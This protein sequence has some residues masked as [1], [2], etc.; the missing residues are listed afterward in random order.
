MYSSLT[1]G[2]GWTD[3]PVGRCRCGCGGQT[4][5]AK[6]GDPRTGRVKG[7]PLRYLP[8]HHTRRRTPYLRFWTGHT[9]DC[10]IWLGG[11]NRKG[12]GVTA[13]RRGGCALAHRVYYEEAKGPIPEG[14]Q[15]DHLCCLP[16]CVN[17]DHLEAVTPAQNVRRGRK[18]KLTPEQVDEI[19]G[20]AE[21]Q[22]VLA[23]RYGITQP[24]VSRIK[25]GQTW[26]SS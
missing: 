6:S 7:E 9:S 18:T 21:T 8:G 12:Y 26:R 17:P 16:A 3:A 2:S 25:Q 24:H 13:D 20:S 22:T 1:A 19:R 4:R 10:W 11:R 5:L 14:L 23:R 15:I